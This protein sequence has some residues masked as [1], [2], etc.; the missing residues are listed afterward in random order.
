MKHFVLIMI[1]NQVT[2]F[3]AIMDVYFEKHGKYIN[4]LS[5]QYTEFLSFKISCTCTYHCAL[6]RTSAAVLPFT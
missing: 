1:M 5:V 2:L 6:K 4:T 3:R